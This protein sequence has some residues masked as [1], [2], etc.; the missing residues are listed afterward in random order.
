[1]THVSHAEQVD[2]ADEL[3]EEEADPVVVAE[4]LEG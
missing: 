1:M 4:T 2:E 3:A